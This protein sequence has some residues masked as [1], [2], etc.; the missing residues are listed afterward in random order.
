MGILENVEGILEKIDLGRFGE[1][2]AEYGDACAEWNGLA[3]AE[4]GAANGPG[5]DGLGWCWAYGLAV[6]GHDRWE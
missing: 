1:E 3:P 5:L 4:L 2:E 6:L